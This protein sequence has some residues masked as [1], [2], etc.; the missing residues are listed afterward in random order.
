MSFRKLRSF[1]H[2]NLIVNGFKL[3]INPPNVPGRGKEW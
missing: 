2:L 1:T 3:V